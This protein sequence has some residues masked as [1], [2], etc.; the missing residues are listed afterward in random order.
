MLNR[1]DPTLLFHGFHISP[2]PWVELVLYRPWAY[3]W[4]NKYNIMVAH[5]LGWSAFVYQ[6]WS[7]EMIQCNIQTSCEISHLLECTMINNAEKPL[8][9]SDRV[10]VPLY[11]L[12][13]VVAIC[14]PLEVPAYAGHIVQVTRL[15]LILLTGC[16]VAGSLARD[17]FYIDDIRKRN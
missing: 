10:W 2:I 13:F 11:G 5:A 14:C 16:P 12:W 6:W 3:D 9:D 7:I 1:K 17:T 15:V 8:V 4:G